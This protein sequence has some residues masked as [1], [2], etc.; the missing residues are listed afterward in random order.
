MFK[1]LRSGP[2]NDIVEYGDKR[3]IKWS[4][5]TQ[6]QIILLGEIHLYLENIPLQITRKTNSYNGN[7]W[8]RFTNTY[9]Y[10][11]LERERKIL[12]LF[13]CET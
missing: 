4:I 11:Y 7:A 13:I 5:S 12:S 8:S 6:G 1:L 9:I 10:I 3:K 2:K